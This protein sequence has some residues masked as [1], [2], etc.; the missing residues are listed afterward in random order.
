MRQFILGLIVAAL[1][2]WG[3]GKWNG[4]AEGAVEASQRP[5]PGVSAADRVLDD[6]MLAGPGSGS[7]AAPA[8]NTTGAAAPVVPVPSPV[9][10]ATLAAVD[11][12]LTRVAERD[13]EAIGKAW[14]IVSARSTAAAAV[15]RRVYESLATPG[16]DFA[17]LLAGLGPHNAFLHSP[18]G[19]A[20]A[21]KVL[22]LALSMA[23]PEAAAA[24]T[25][26][27][28]LCL[29]GRIEKGDTDARAFVDQAYQR[30]R[31]VAD[32]WVCDPANVTGA[33]S[34]TVVRGD[35]LARIAQNFRKQGIKVEDGTLAILNRIHNVNA[36]QVDQRI[37]VPVA[38]ILAV[39]EKRSFALAIYV[40]DHLLRLYWVGHG[41]NDH[42]P[43]TEFTVVEKQAK[44]Q[45]TAPDGNVYP[46]G[47]PQNIL[48]EYFIKFRHDT[49]TGFGAHGTPMPETICTQSSAG[50][51]RMLKDDIAEMYRFLPRGAAVVVRATESIK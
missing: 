9:D 3:Y 38:P 16:D 47:H 18:E 42:T 7:G 22:D 15:K 5:A 49:Y 43:V 50:C 45:W 24:G 33:R 21:Q 28:T 35:S 23:D 26:L 31:V 13:A 46:Y 51:I 39:L 48:G 36:L 44:P 20:A 37:K 6:M 4:N 8:A 41:A 1:A 10:D 2:W 11:N 27:L 29:R 30:Y 19:R 32:R 40:G 14:S 12:L 17:A 34:Y 25:A